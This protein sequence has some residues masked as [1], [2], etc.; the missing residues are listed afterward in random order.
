MYLWFKTGHSHRPALVVLAVVIFLFDSLKEKR[1]VPLTAW[2]GTACFTN[3]C[4]ALLLKIPGLD[5]V[6]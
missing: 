6:A 3:S 5:D 2:S 4:S 1:S